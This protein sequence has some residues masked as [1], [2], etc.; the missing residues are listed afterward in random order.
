MQPSPSRNTLAVRLNVGVLRFARHWLRIFLI[1][2]GA[3]AALPWV[4]PTLMQ[5]GLEAPAR[6]LYFAYGP[7]CHQFAFRSF[8]L[9]GDQ[10]AY[11]RAIANSTFVP[12][13]SYI[14]DSPLFDE[15]LK[16]WIGRPAS[17]YDTIEAFDPS[18]WTF[19]LQ[20]ASR[21]FFGT[22]EMGYK[23]AL[24]QRDVALYGALFL[25]GLVY[26]FPAI[27]RRLRPVPLWLYVVAGVA[28]IGL[29]GFSQ[30]LGYLPL[31][32]WAPRETTPIFRV[33]TGAIFGLM[34]AWLAFPYLEQSFQATRAEIEDKLRRAGVNF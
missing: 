21:D 5:L 14:D 22:P 19:D 26:S 7:F 20:F 8:F 1:V 17:R 27:R 16:N 2:L 33:L 15:A 9:F 24:C 25:G 6:A 13:E 12:Y 4:A 29:D 28:P 30:L 34:T 11:P 18:V 3:Y 23:T 31:P 10:A 32:P